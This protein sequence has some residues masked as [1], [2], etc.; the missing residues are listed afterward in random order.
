MH[1]RGSTLELCLTSLC[2]YMY[3]SRGTP[4]DLPPYMYEHPVRHQQSA[5]E[6]YMF[7]AAASAVPDEDQSDDASYRPRSVR[8]YV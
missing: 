6:A 1:A 3:L 8:Y 2:F 4:T 5:P 7:A